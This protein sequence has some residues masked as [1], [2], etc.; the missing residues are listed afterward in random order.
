VIDPYELRSLLATLR[1]AEDPHELARGA[2]FLAVENLK[3]PRA[4][5]FMREGKQPEAFWYDSTSRVVSSATAQEREAL[6][7]L[8]PRAGVPAIRDDVALPGSDRCR[9]ALAPYERGGN[10]GFLLVA[11]RES[12]YDARDLGILWTLS[13]AVA[14]GLDALLG[15]RRSKTNRLL[16]HYLRTPLWT[17]TLALEDLEKEPTP[18]SASLALSAS[19]VLAGQ[20]D[21]FTCNFDLEDQRFASWLPLG[22]AL[23]AIRSLGS[24]W[25]R[26]EQREFELFDEDLPRADQITTGALQLLLT[27]LNDAY[28]DR[29]ASGASLVLRKEGDRLRVFLE[30]A[31]ILTN[32]E[33][34]LGDVVRH[35][36][37]AF[38]SEYKTARTVGGEIHELLLPLLPP[39]DL[40]LSSRSDRIPRILAAD[41]S[42]VN[43]EA[44]L[45]LLRL[46]G[47]ETREARDG[48]EALEVAKSEFLD[49]IFM[50]LLMPRL[51]GVDAA[52]RIR[53]A[54]ISVPIVALTA[55][56]TEDMIE[57][58][59]AGMND[60]IFKPVSGRL[61][62]EMVAQYTGF[63]PER[64]G[65][66]GR[67]EEDRKERA[68]R[69]ALVDS[70]R[71]SLPETRE[72]LRAALLSEDRERAK[73]LSHRL[74]GEAAQ[75]GFPELSEAAARIEAATE[76]RDPLAGYS[77]SAEAL[78]LPEEIGEA[79]A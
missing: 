52:R 35:L 63:V 25:T 18:E 39:T 6:A 23:G 13:E 43:R 14:I 22:E 1:K 77:A 70:L 60:A 5:L 73:L 75:A 61:L 69:S 40:R 2:L 45:R 51:G 48:L 15:R 38:A 3:S 76:R 68:F 67:Q 30:A 10:S 57:A 55:G 53:E 42:D 27:L 17:L 26:L 59:E 34:L 16:G 4:A 58:L 74:K 78:R 19:R 8:E 41:D 37:R 7:Q 65:R 79:G 66:G 46:W 50:D 56:G 54:G 71:Q 72:Q 64:K 20:I 29:R 9:V 28:I 49:L 11:C 21:S 47:V 31:G 62:M 32:Q 12:R 33:G 44:L 36:A 24:A